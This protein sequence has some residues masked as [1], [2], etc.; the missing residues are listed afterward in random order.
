MSLYKLVS[1]S[2]SSLSM[3]EEKLD[4]E[5]YSLSCFI[6]AVSLLLVSENWF[7]ITTKQRFIIKNVPILKNEEIRFVVFE[8][9]T[10]NYQNNKVDKIVEGVSVLNNVHNI[11]PSFQWDYLHNTTRVCIAV[12][13]WYSY[14]RNIATHA[15]PILSNETAPWNGLWGPVL[16]LV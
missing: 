11:C 16:Q 6:F 5:E 9:Q 3:K 1:S 8:N 10:Y 4:S 14:T 15:S 7:A 13:Q 2:S 12:C